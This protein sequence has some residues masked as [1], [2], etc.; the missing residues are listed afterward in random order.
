MGSTVAKEDQEYHESLNTSGRLSS[1]N[2]TKKR[3]QAPQ[4]PTFSKRSAAENKGPR[5]TPKFGKERTGS[6]TPSKTNSKKKSLV[7]AEKSAAKANPETK[8]EVDDIIK[9][10][11]AP[12]VEESA[13]TKPQVKSKAKTPSKAPESSIFGKSER[14]K[15][16]KKTSVRANI[17]ANV[18]RA[19]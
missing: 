16:E 9:Q 8:N 19:S 4:A 7:T 14:D 2:I 11:E 1:R 12:D 6:S 13:P 17:I 18:E 3:L 15:T 10:E 5:E